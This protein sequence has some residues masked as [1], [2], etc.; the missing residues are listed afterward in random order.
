VREA[1]SLSREEVEA[2]LRFSG[3]LVMENRLKKETKGFLR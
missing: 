3:L 1:M 2:G